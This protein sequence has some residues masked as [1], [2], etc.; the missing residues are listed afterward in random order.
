MIR[1]GYPPSSSPSK[2]S[3]LTE[4]HRIPPI[5]LS[6]NEVVEGTVLKTLSSDTALLFIKGKRLLARTAVPLSEGRLL[7]LRVQEPLPVPTLRIVGMRYTDSRAVNMALILSAVKDNLWE[8]IS[9]GIVHSGLP[10]E[11]IEGFKQLMDDMSLRLFS[12]QTPELLRTLIDISGLTWEAKLRTA[13][14]SRGLRGDDF[15]KLLEG[16]LKGLASR[17]LALSGER[18]Q[19]L[20]QFV[21]TLSNIQILNHLGLEQGGRVFLPVP[22][23]L[24]NG[25]FTVA[26]LLIEL[27]HKEDEY[28]KKKGSKDFSRVTFLL[29]LSSLGPLRADLTLRGKAIDGRFL[30]TRTEAKERVEEAVP[31]FTSRLEKM[32]FT[33]NSMKCHLMDPAKLVHSLAREIIPD[34]GYTLNLFA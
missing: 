8:S 21:S 1:V 28:R 20:E 29:E 30:L 3:L 18:V 6:R 9:Q 11:T 22:I 7:S 24:P 32:G 13:F 5:K 2:I 17:L 34:E 14:G 33:V 15:A 26:Q 25:L 10:R 16:D 19:L 23:Q 12:K 4:S 31:G 27:P